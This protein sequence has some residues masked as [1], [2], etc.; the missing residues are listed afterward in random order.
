MKPPSIVIV[1]AG[2]AGIR[3]AETIIQAG[4]R[5][6]VVDEG[7]QCGGQIYRQPPSGI[8]R[9]P[10][11]LYG[12]EAQK[13]SN[14]HE[15]FASILD[16]IDYRPA[17]TVWD[18]S[19]NKLCVLSE[20]GTKDV[21]W[22]RLIL[23]TGAMD[24]VIPFKGWTQPGVFTLGGSQVA[25]KGQACAIGECP[26]FVGTGPLLYLVA[27]Q[28]LLAGVRPKAVLDTSPP[29]AQRRAIVGL[30]RGGRTFLKGLL[31]IAQLKRAGVR[32]ASGIRPLAANIGEDG[33]VSNF[34]WLDHSGE[35]RSAICDSIAVGFGL[36]SETQ[37]ADLCGVPFAY[38][39]GQRQWLPAQD[40]AGRA[41]DIEGIYFAGDGAG[42]KG[43]DA[44]ELLGRRAAH[45]LLLD[46][47]HAESGRLLANINRRIQRMSTFRHA[48]DRVAFP[49]PHRLAAAIDDA[50]ILCRCEGVAAGELRRIGKELGA[51]EVNRAKAFCRVGMGR[52]Q[53]RVCGEI[54]AEV[55]AEC[56]DVSIEKVGRI[57]GQAPVK[58]ISMRA[59]A[60]ASK[61]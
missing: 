12:F 7:D 55:L 49:F 11:A 51:T 60:E 54:A 47:G 44:A 6:T 41:E 21:H 18:A 20:S 45:A 36:R 14:L 43:A 24:R 15:S 38:D 5:P 58:P 61:S 56:L 48:L 52:C 30:M 39:K 1:G 31:Y 9:S 4:Y 10:K 16:A 27:Y 40:S 23:A 17:S 26:V 35:M 3:A 8:R 37:L 13:A 34:S 59:F 53:G 32:I 22:D 50:T 2:P 46:L 42:V 28:Y 19:E 25:L 33:S 29:K 57:R